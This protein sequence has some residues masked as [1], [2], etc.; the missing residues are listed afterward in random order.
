MLVSVGPLGKII[1]EEALAVGMA[2]DRVHVMQDNK[3]AADLLESLIQNGDVVLI[4][5]SLGAR[6]DQIVAR[7]SRSKGQV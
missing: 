3:Q 1:G 2:R 7:L 6:M 5:G 4:K